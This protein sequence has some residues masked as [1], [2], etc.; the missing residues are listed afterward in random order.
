[1]TPKKQELRTALKDCRAARR[2][3]HKLASDI[4]ADYNRQ[5]KAIDRHCAQ[6]SRRET[7]LHEQLAALKN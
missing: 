5:M 2:T 4:S 7:K 6:I 1:M 3:W